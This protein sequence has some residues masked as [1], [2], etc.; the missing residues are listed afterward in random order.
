[1]A[2]EPR[3]EQLSEHVGIYRDV[4]NVGVI[5]Q[6]SKTLI[7]D[8]G[9]G[10]ILRE[11]ERLGLDPVVRVL[12]THYHRD[13]C[14]GAG[15]LQ[16]AG[17]KIGVPAS[18][19]RFFR[20]ATEFW[21]EADAI[22]DHRYNFRS[23]MMV[24]RESVAPDDE[25]GSGD[26]FQWEGILISVLSTPGHT[27]GSVTYL[28]T[29]DGNTFA[30]TGDLIYG[31]GQVWEFY[32]LQSRFPGMPGDYWGFGAAVAELGK[33]LDTVL[34]R[35]PTLL[36]LSHGAVIKNPGEAVALL[37]TNLHA[38][39]TNYFTTAAWRIYFS[40]HFREAK[41]KAI[42]T[43]LSTRFRWFRPCLLPVRPRGCTS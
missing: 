19:A 7:I 25:L 36:L 32:S 21:L 8:C 41:V 5:R 16:K 4:V 27:E 11:G 38:A 10:S 22:L 35:K 28:V 43:P 29:L 42:P 33:S 9:E 26:T 23:E 1:M 15:L 2:S 31:P 20:S 12:F 17:V 6:N 39:M 18:E 3:F 13:Q 14:S 30:F 34:S 37:K 24:L 40:G